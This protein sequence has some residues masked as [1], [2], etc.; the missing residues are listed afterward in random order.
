MHEAGHTMPHQHNSLTFS[1]RQLTL[2]HTPLTLPP[3]NVPSFSL[4]SH[5]R[6]PLSPPAPT[7]TSYILRWV[8]TYQ[9][10]PKYQLF[11]ALAKNVAYLT[12]FY[13]GSGMQ[14]LVKKNVC[15]GEINDSDRAEGRAVN[16]HRICL[17]CL[18]LLP[19]CPALERYYYDG[20]YL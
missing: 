15:K 16:Q 5:R 13:P 8:G 12:Y 2:F 10:T 7:T 1:A 18:Q 4:C 3:F 11:L 9:N 19:E 20:T 6:P 17:K 14:S